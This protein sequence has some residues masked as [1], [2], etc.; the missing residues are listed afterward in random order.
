MRAVAITVALL[1]VG[2]LAMLATGVPNGRAFALCLT[3]LAF[4]L[5]TLLVAAADPVERPGI[6]FIESARQRALE[7]SRSIERGL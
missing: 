5:S 1:N 6:R 4:S 3:A 2:T 7:V